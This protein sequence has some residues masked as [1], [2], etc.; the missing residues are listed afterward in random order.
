MTSAATRQVGDIA[1]LFIHY[2][3]GSY[4]ETCK[5][6]NNDPFWKQVMK[7]YKLPPKR[8]F[9]EGRITVKVFEHERI[10]FQEFTVYYSAFSTIISNIADTCI[11]KLDIFELEQK[12]LTNILYYAELL[13]EHTKVYRASFT[14]RSVL[15]YTARR[16]TAIRNYRYHNDDDSV[17]ESS[18]EE[19]DQILTDDD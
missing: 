14:E 10:C 12:Q 2:A 13:M 6:V 3:N 15:E 16:A 19:E 1:T 17:S 7:K 11:D 4:D 18:S 9:I 5:Y 8:H